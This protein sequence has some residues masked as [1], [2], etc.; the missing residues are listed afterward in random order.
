MT[1]VFLIALATYRITHLVVFDRIFMPIRNLFVRREFRSYDGESYIRYT[2]PG[3]RLR[4]LV[5]KVLNCPW[6]ASVWIA[7]GL[8]A[9]YVYGP[10]WMTWVYVFLAAAA[11][12][13]LLETWWTKT[14]GFPAE[15]VEA[16]KYAEED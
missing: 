6:C 16:G 13:G 5:G 9:L 7:G 11:I 10:A 4:R 1:V 14:V 15:M 3:G 8:T 2:L 12:T